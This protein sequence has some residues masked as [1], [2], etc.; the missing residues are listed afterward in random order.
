MTK[1]MEDKK[2]KCESK[3]LKTDEKNIER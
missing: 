2:N 3:V 1:K